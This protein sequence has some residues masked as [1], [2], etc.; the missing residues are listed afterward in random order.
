MRPDEDD[1]EQCNAELEGEAPTA[2]AAGVA[3]EPAL[4]AEDAGD[5]LGDGLAAPTA[6]GHYERAAKKSVPRMGNMLMVE[7]T[8]TVAIRSD[9]HGCTS[10]TYVANAKISEL[11]EADEATR[12]DSQEEIAREKAV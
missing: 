4:T 5:A 8:T 11:L 2:F 9:I 3:H 10:R 7:V 1:P 6:R 12:L